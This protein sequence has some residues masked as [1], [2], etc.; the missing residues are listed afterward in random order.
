MILKPWDMVEAYCRDQQMLSRVFRS[1]APL[2]QLSFY[3]AMVP[4]FIL[5]L[6]HCLCQGGTKDGSRVNLSIKKLLLLVCSH[7]LA[8]EKES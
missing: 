4:C 6:L 5:Y 7:L 2:D 1:G 8:E 3:G